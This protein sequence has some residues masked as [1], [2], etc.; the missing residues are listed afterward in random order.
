[1]VWFGKCGQLAQPSK[2]ARHLPGV[3][4][5]DMVVAV[6][7]VAASFCSSRHIGLIG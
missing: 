1:M 4:P 7:A 2:V 3:S 5:P 6:V